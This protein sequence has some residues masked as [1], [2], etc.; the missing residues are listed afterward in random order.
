MMQKCF[1]ATRM[2]VVVALCLAGAGSYAA[3]PALPYKDPQ[4]PIERRV[5]DLLARM[6][7]EEKLTQITAI[8]SQKPQIFD[9]KGDVDPARLA[10]VYPNGI[11]Q[12]SRPNDLAGA[13]QLAAGAVPRRAPHRGA[14]ERHPEIPDDAHAPGYSDP[15]SRRGRAW[16][17]GTRRHQ[18]PAFRSASRAAGIPRSSNA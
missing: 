7:L 18:L 9:S 5:D 11:G 17:R 8:W 15:V 16:L 4:T 14:G 12:F 10:K 6:T 3:A 1:H 13:G 2:C